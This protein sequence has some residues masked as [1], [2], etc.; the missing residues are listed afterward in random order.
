VCVVYHS[1]Y[2]KTLDIGMHF[3]HGRACS[4]QGPL[5][6][7]TCV[8]RMTSRKWFQIIL[9]F[10]SYLLLLPVFFFVLNSNE[11]IKQEVCE[12]FVRSFVRSFSSLSLLS[13][14][15]SK[16]TIAPS[17]GLQQRTTSCSTSTITGRQ[18]FV[19]LHIWVVRSP[20]LF[21]QLNIISF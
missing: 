2:R 10:S 13:A 5:H 9:F 17:V 20:S 11:T 18:T 3:L 12:L 6:H 16:Q 4:N 8:R 7:N 21:A 1:L 14:R 19:D 15:V